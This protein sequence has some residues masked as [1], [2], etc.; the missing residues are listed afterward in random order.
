MFI[1]QPVGFLDR[2]GEIRHKDDLAKVAPGHGSHVR[3]W[4]NGKLALDRRGQR[5]GQAF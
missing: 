3:R 2:L 4:Q 1:S 5:V